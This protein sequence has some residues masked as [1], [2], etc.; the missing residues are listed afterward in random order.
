M[1]SHTGKGEMYGWLKGAILLN[2]TAAA[3]GLM[4]ACWKVAALPTLTITSTAEGTYVVQDAAAGTSTP[5]ATLKVARAMVA[6][7]LA[8]CPEAVKH[9]SALATPP[10]GGVAE[11]APVVEAP[12][13]EAPVQEAAPVVEAPAPKAKAKGKGKG[14]K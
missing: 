5:A 7:T 2:K 3:N 11:A 6:V 9:N 14:K 10:E 12:V 8:A 4:G 13:Q 1:L